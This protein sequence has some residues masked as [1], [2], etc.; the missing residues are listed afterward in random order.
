MSNLFYNLGRTVG[1][2]TIP[3][4]RKSKSAWKSLVGNE[5]ESIQ[6]Q[7]EFGKSLAAELRLKVRLSEDAEA[8]DLARGILNKLIPCVRNKLRTF[9]LE[10]LA[11]GTPTAVSLPGGFLFLSL[12]LLDFCQRVPDEVAF[13]IGHEM[14]HVVRGHALERILKR[15]GIE[16]LSSI[17]SRGLV[18]PAIRETGLKW[19]ESSYLRDAE[20]EA[21]EFGVRV[22]WAAGYDPSA[23]LR[24]LDR[25][26]TLRTSGN[27]LGD[28][29]ASHPSEQERAVPIRALLKLGDSPGKPP[30]P[31]AGS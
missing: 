25:I 19:L 6:A 24:V 21:D 14:G 8:R 16:G 9:H 22:A 5:T 26:S 4:I 15:I 17:V 20:V 27:P 1:Y 10:V 13:L 3:A 2:A 7:A 23:A 12:G 30:T 29:F 18:N 28:Y 31:E 11:E